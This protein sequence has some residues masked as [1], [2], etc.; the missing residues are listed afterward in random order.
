M[1]PVRHR[2]RNHR[3]AAARRPFDPGAADPLRAAQPRA[4]QED[5]LARRRPRAAGV[6]LVSIQQMTGLRHASA[7]ATA[8]SR[9]SASREGGRGFGGSSVALAAIAAIALATFGI[10]RGTRAVGGSDS[11]CYALM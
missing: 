4:R 3:Q 11:S 1:Q 9:R 6:G 10:V 8:R 5:R 7:E 2:A